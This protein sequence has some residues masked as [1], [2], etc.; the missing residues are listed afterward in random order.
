M[1]KAKGESVRTRESLADEIGEEMEMEMEIARRVQVFPLPIHQT[2]TRFEPTFI[3]TSK[4]NPPLFTHRPTCS[5]ITS[6]IV[7]KLQLS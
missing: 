4:P 5:F 3:R 2:S 1:L 7:L 6:T